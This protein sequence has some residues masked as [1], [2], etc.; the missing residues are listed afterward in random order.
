MECLCFYR[1]LPE[2]CSLNMI[3]HC[4]LYSLECVSPLWYRTFQQVWLLS[5]WWDVIGSVLCWLGLHFMT[6][7][8]KI[9]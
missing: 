8:G 4:L 3:Q 9:K 7:S 5:V 6:F 2:I 1:M